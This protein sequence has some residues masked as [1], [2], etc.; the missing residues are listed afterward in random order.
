M[1][2]R[3]YVEI[4]KGSKDDLLDV[5]ELTSKLQHQ[6]ANV[7]NDNL[8]Y[9]S[10]PALIASTINCMISQCESVDQAKSYR[11]LFINLFEEA[12][13]DSPLK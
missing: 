12:L 4:P 9:L 6:I 8:M 7:L 10:M 5:M 13:K 2:K 3:G 11:D 1:R